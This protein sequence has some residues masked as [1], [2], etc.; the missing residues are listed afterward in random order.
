MKQSDSKRNDFVKANLASAK[1]HVY[2]SKKVIQDPHQDD[3]S[4]EVSGL[5][6][7]SKPTGRR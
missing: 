5:Q 6:K 2:N 4:A 1:N 7:L 3:I